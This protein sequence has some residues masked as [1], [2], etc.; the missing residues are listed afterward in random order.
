[1]PGIYNMLDIS[2]W[3]L[4]ANTRA[5]DTVSHNVANVNTAGYSRQETVLA[6]R[7]AQFASEGWY[8]NGVKVANVIQHVDKL[9]Q[10]QITDKSTQMGYYDSRL[11]QLQRLEALDNEAGDSSLGKSLTSFFNAWQQLSLNSESTAVRQAVRESAQ[12]LASRLNTISQDLAQVKRDLN[13]YLG[14]GVTEINQIC[15]RIADLNSKIISTEAMGKAAN[16]FRDERQR[17]IEDLSQK[18]NI[19]WFEDGKGSVSIFTGQGAVLV[20]ENYPRSGD[21]DP[22]AFQEMTGYTDK[23]V[24]WTGT[25]Q[26]LGTTQIT[27]GELGAWLKVRD[28]DL[29]GMQD[30]MDELTENLVWEVNFQHSQG[31]GQTKFTDVTGTYKSVDYQTALNASTNTLPFK[32]Q[33]QSG[34]LTVWVYEA[35]TRRS[36]TV[37]VDPND[38]ITAVA[39]KI[40]AVI[41][42]TLNASLNPV[43]TVENGQ[44]LR[45]HATGG[46]EFSFANDTSGLLAAM[47][48]NTFFD[49]YNAGNLGVNALVQA[50]VAR[51]AAGRLLASGEQAVGDNSNALDLADLKDLDAMASG[52]QTFNEAVISFASSLGSDIANTEDSQTF[53]Q[54]ANTQLQNMRD[55][56]SAVNLDEEMIKMIQYQRAYQSAAKMISVADEMLQTLLNTKR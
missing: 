6:T 5:L 13:G 18:L 3:A 24:V 36:Y 14:A 49:G 50:D 16:D 17:Q 34:S 31:T 48:I 1:M 10:Q 25:N 46:I 15:R 19:Q 32:D 56:V 43:A 40:N 54:S 33:L 20:Q 7:G 8:G 37:N 51:I 35:G 4:H 38:H 27:G 12:N 28:E 30:F 52:T 23:Q 9:I 39:Q 42:P 41:N 21:A 11:S 26:V 29:Q 53:A 44:Q 22:L 45:F 47:G 55:Q 2:R